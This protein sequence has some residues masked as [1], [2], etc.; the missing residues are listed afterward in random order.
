MTE[1]LTDRGQALAVNNPN[2]RRFTFAIRSVFTSQ[3][4]GLAKCLFGGG[5][6]LE[7]PKNIDV[8]INNSSLALNMVR[9]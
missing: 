2:K 8:V 1:S 4:E 3:E 6:P 7:M 9:P 5:V